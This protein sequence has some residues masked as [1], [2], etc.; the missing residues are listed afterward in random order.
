MPLAF[1]WMAQVVAEGTWC[2]KRVPETISKV[3]CKKRGAIDSRRG[4]E[5]IE[6]TVLPIIMK[7]IFE[8]ER[9]LI[10]ID[11]CIV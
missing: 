11:E 5:H 6:P 4:R 3:A 8:E 7:R 2:N 9:I 10:N 1:K